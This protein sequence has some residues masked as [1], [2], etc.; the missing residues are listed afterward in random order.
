MTISFTPGRAREISWKAYAVRFAFGGLVTFGA[1][2]IGMVYGPA[3]GGLF[4]AFPS[5]CMAS[6][7]L[8]ERR[9]GKSAVGVDAV[10]A[11]IGSVGLLSFGGI[12]W[13]LAPREPA[14]LT[15][16]VACC[17]WFMVSFLLWLAFGW[18]RH[19]R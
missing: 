13:L 12:L 2:I 5:I 17:V 14:W 9:E 16:V 18:V 4:L 11:S 19:A 8:L 10:G 7:T 15:L 1:G 3:V 6:M